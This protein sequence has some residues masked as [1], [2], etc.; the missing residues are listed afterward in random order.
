[1][2]GTRNTATKQVPDAQ[3]RKT[4][5]LEDF[6]A[7]RNLLPSLQLQTVTPNVDHDQV[8]PLSGVAQGARDRVANVSVQATRGFLDKVILGF[9]Q[10][11]SDVRSC[12]D[13]VSWKNKDSCLI[14]RL[15]EEP[16]QRLAPDHLL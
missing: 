12:S 5:S 15:C 6:M 3:Q 16:N 8:G 10:L 14:D 7:R 11:V 2:T 9:L 13:Q 1:M 4:H